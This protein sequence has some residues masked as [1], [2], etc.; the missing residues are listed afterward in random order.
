MNRSWVFVSR[1]LVGRFLL[2][3]RG[4]PMQDMSC[5]PNLEVVVRPRKTN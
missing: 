5:G 2:L 3:L 4:R 1:S